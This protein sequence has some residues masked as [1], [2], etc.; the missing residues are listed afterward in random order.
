MC[1]SESKSVLDRAKESEGLYVT[2]FMSG[3]GTQSEQFTIIAEVISCP[4]GPFEDKCEI[5][6][7]C[8]NRYSSTW[9]PGTSSGRFSKVSI[10]ELSSNKCSILTLSILVEKFHKVGRRRRA[11]GNGSQSA[12]KTINYYH[13]CKLVDEDNNYCITDENGDDDCWTN[14]LCSGRNEVKVQSLIEEGR[15]VS[16]SDPT[17]ENNAP[18]TAISISVVAFVLLVL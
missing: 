13:P 4:L 14:E 9:Y 16:S 12:T 15:N 7:T 6:D 11:T 5:G 1:F 8:S 3:N 18:I 17:S 2:P 10:Y